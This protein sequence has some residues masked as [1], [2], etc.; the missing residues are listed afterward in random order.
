MEYEQLEELPV[1]LHVV[2]T[3]VIS[4]EELRLSRGRCSTR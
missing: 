2:A 4:G 1:P 3:D